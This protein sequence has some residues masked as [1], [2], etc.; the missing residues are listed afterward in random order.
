[1]GPR[2]C[3]GAENLAPTGIQ[4]PDRPARSESLYRLSYPGPRGINLCLFYFVTQ[5]LGN[6]AV[7]I[8]ISGL[9]CICDLGGER[10]EVGG[11][12]TG[13]VEW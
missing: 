1:L 5:V 10:C 2:A 9:S 13:N 3:L 8:V 4:S 7:R 12:K 6:C 11:R